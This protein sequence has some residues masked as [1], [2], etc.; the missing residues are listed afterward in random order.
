VK[1]AKKLLQEYTPDLVFLDINLGDGSGFDLIDAQSGDKFKIIF[2]TAYDQFAIRAFECSALDY[3]LKPI[4]PERFSQTLHKVFKAET[5]KDDAIQIAE[6]L[7]IKQ[8]GLVNKLLIKTE[9]GINIAPTDKIIRLEAN[10]SY[11][12]IYME[13]GEKIVSSK[14]LGELEEALPV[15]LFFR[16]HKSH[17]INLD[18]VT[19]YIKEDGGFLMLVNGEKIGISRRSKEA[20][21]DMI[22]R[23]PN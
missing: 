14:P 17:I 16:C 9:Q 4:S 20:F 13:S 6:M 11:T 22:Q 18:K 21:M 8:N 2:I 5:F 12:I 1:S 15:H 3:L 23:L 10:G 19:K 7:R